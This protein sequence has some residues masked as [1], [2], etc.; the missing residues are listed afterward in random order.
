MTAVGIVGLECTGSGIVDV[1]PYTQIG[2]GATLVENTIVGG[3]E[4]GTEALL[5]VGNGFGAALLHPLNTTKSVAGNIEDA[6]SGVLVG[7][8]IFQDDP[9]LNPTARASRKTSHLLGDAISLPGEEPFPLRV[10]TVN[11]YPN[12]LLDPL[13][14]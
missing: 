10:N 4:K 12:P 13:A 5:S 1:L 9:I 7:A 2:P 8:N 6:M 11:G 3:L 14:W